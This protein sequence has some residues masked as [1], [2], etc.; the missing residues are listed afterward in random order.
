MEYIGPNIKPFKAIAN[1]GF[2]NMADFL[3]YLGA[4][5]GRFDANK[6]L[7]FQRTLKGH[8]TRKVHEKQKE[9]FCNHL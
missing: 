3:V 8:A 9:V 1:P 6:V 7:P 5:Y 2:R 4:K